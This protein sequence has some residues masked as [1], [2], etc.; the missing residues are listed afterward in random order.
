M[1]TLKEHVESVIR[2]SFTTQMIEPDFDQYYDKHICYCDHDELIDIL[3]EAF[4]KWK[5][6]LIRETKK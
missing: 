6:E 4:E 1:K 5:I 3:S 2:E